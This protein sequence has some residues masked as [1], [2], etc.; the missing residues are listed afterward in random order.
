MKV[1]R[2]IQAAGDQRAF[3]LIELLVVVSLIVLLVALLLPALGRAREIGRRTVCASN[4]QQIGNAMLSQA[5][6]SGGRLPL[7]YVDS[8]HG[9]TYHMIWAF[10][11]PHK[12]MMLGTLVESGAVGGG[13]VFYC[14]SQKWSF[15]QY[16][17][18]DNRW[19]EPYT[20]N[21]AQK[22]TRSGYNVRPFFEGRTW[23]WGTHSSPAPPPNLARIQ[24]L[25][26]GTTIAADLISIRTWTDASH[27]DGVNRIGV[28]GGV[29][30]VQRDV[31]D[32]YLETTLHASLAEQLWTSL[33]EN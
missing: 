31:F 8:A 19:D 11:S 10:S 30:W 17:T 33:D 13:E 9:S 21:G 29:N 24:S 15:F 7:G 1:R 3:T 18:P 4:L 28:D 20:S 25:P 12:Y 26:S 22:I 5:A 16:D 23:D 2:P 6:D 32:D 14:P 27:A